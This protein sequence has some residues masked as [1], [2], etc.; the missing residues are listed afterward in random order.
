[1]SSISALA[2]AIR[3]LVTTKAKRPQKKKT[4][5]Q[6]LPQPATELD[7]ELRRQ[8]SRSRALRTFGIISILAV[9][10][11]IAAALFAPGPD[12]KLTGIPAAPLDSDL[13][14]HELQSMTGARITHSNSIEP[15]PNGNNFYEAE[16]QAIQNARSTINIEAYIFQRGDMSR[17]VLTALTERAK[18]GV[19]VRMVVD[20]LGSFSTPKRYF[21][22]F[23]QAGGK[24]E[25]Y[26]PLR[27]N[28]WMRS[29]N[30]THRELLIVDAKE[31]FVGGAGIAD[32][33]YYDRPPKHPRWRDEMFRVHGEAV[34]SIQG[35]FLE[36]WLEAS[37]EL[38]AGEQFFGLEPEAGKTTVLVMPSSPSQGGSTPA[39]VLFQ[40][41]LASAH[42]SIQITTPYFL[43]DKSMTRQLVDAR[44]RGVTVRI[45][46]PGGKSDHVMTRS[47]SR[48]TYGP[49]LLAGV[50]IFEYQ[51]SMVHAKIMVID[52]LWSVIG[53]TNMDNRSFGL[54]DE[55]N[56]ASVDPQLAA[57]LEQQFQQ[58][59]S[60][61]DPESYDKWKRRPLWQRFVEWFGWV[62]ESQQ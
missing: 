31:A 50:E 10:G 38:I 9:L 11:W 20:A 61:A 22:E 6:D 58:D 24:M 17:R 21:K 44:K 55:V 60:K 51:P 33:W 1:L 34:R 23:K 37:G 45:L 52:G 35:V 27:W 59:I 39:R 36:N 15:I 13:F 5:L 7:A 26:H 12:Y 8:F 16:L 30:R 56:L 2:A 41:L 4:F 25:F 14:I 53:T 43:P 28:T 57:N 3:L 47:S 48:R 18:S 49:L 19:Q 62:L 46:V 54:N 40:T 32:H 29:N 42:R